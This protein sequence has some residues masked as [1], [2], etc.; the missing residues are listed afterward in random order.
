MQVAQ[1]LHKLMSGENA[2]RKKTTVIWNDRCQQ[3]FDELKCLCKTVPV[4]AYTD[5]Y[6]PF[7][8][9]TNTCG[10]GL[11]AVLYQIH[12]SG[13]SAIIA[14]ASMSLAKAETH[15][16]THKLGLLT[17]KWAVVEKFHKY[18]Y[19][20]TFNVYTNNNPLV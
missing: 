19:G 5:F 1:P 4:L 20:L 14:Y 13:T 18:L 16:P 11:G 7:K 12:D 2:G 15:Y 17:L 3:A 9:Q 6:R 10:S 8:L